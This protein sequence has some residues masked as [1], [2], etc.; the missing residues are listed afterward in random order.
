MLERKHIVWH[1]LLK[2]LYGNRFWFHFTCISE[3]A[4]E[5]P[6]FLQHTH[7]LKISQGKHEIRE[8]NCLWQLSSMCSGALLVFTELC[9]REEGA[10]SQSALSGLPRSASS[11][12]DLPHNE[13]WLPTHYTSSLY[14]NVFKSK[15][16][17]GSS[18]I[19][20][21]AVISLRWMCVAALCAGTR[22][23]TPEEE[24]SPLLESHFQC[25]QYKAWKMIPSFVI[26]ELS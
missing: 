22:T 25:N 21:R 20:P 15:R 5:A 24:W 6:S 8:Q 19:R 2:Y 26:N 14:N 13:D 3:F 1:S 17:W 11:A 9:T 18:W 4:P 16:L 7:A 12:A 10:S 23:H